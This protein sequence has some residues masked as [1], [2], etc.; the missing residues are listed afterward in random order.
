[1][2]FKLSC[3]YMSGSIYL[4]LYKLHYLQNI[5]FTFQKQIHGL[6]LERLLML[7]WPWRMR[8]VSDDLFS[9]YTNETRPGP[10]A[11]QEG[12]LPRAPTCPGPNYNSLESDYYIHPLTSPC[13]NIRLEFVFFFISYQTGIFVAQNC[14]VQH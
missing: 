3:I 8:D 1:M 11:G 4:Y 5:I 6:T 10:G 14:G 2:V 13:M 9:T 7:C 12:Q